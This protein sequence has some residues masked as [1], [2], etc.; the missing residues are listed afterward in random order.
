MALLALTE[1]STLLHSPTTWL[2]TLLV[3]TALYLTS[4]RYQKGLSKIPGPW[5]RSLST[6]PRMWAIYATHSQE[7]DIKLHEKYGKIVRVAPNILSISDTSEINQLY[8]I[9][10]KFTKSGFYS[11]A[12]VYDENGQLFPDPFI[13]KDKDLHSRMKRNAANAYSLNALIQ[14]EPYVDEVLGALLNKLDSFA[15]N[16]ADCDL[17]ETSKDYAMD[18]VTSIT[19]GKN[20]NYINKG[21]HLRFYK[22][23]DVMT[24]Y[25][26]IFGQIPWI[27]AYL[28]KNPRV[29]QWWLKD[30]NS[31]AEIAA[32]SERE[33]EKSRERTTDTGPMTFLER[34]ALNQ[35]TNAASITD[36][37]MLTHA[38]GNISAG[39]DTTA[40]AIRALLYHVLKDERVYKKLAEEVRNNLSPRVAFAAAN[41]LPYLGACIREAMRVHPS[42]GLLLGRT[43]PKGGATICN[44]YVQEGTEVGLNPFV[45]H[46]DPH[47][48]PEPTVFKPER[49]LLSESSEEHLKMMN[50][51]F[52]AFGH[53]AHTCSGRHISILEITKLIPTLLLRYDLELV[54]GGRSY[55]YKNRWFTTQEGLLIKLTRR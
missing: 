6:L 20:F 32:L 34:L 19:F 10:T 35:K 54:D 50:R 49:W 33:I 13:L 28:L 9:T 31:S 7:Y 3:L 27:H 15:A 40:T 53:G 46:H 12:E 18:A 25:M 42:V 22:G 30:D 14:M 29:L 23:L 55:R 26:A 16:G 11:L 5:V 52:F 48:F 2:A 43:V 1:Y 36:H 8:G 24:D 17:G 47:V 38:V 41:D 4:N 45:L 51:C 21:D 44:H 37:E 39:S